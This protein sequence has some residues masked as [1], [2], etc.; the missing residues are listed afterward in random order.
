MMAGIHCR[1]TKPEMKIRTLLHSQGLR[2]RLHDNQLPGKPDVVF[3]KYKAV[4]FVNGCFWHKHDC[5]LFKQPSSN[6]EFWRNKI[7][8][9]CLRDKRNIE[10]LKKLG[11]RV[12]I[13]W[14]CTIRNNRWKTESNYIINVISDWLRS[15]TG[16]LD[17]SENI[18]V[19]NR[20]NTL[21]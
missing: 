12:C 2:Y 15:D 13:I 1:D 19:Q 8:N 14:E 10:E 7:E 21:N 11:W 16:F 20:E 3:P 5:G 6:E 17:V 4:I 9:N 18:Y